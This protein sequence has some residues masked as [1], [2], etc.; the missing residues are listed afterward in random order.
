MNRKMT[1]VVVFLGVLL[2]GPA[3]TTLA[4]VP[5]ANLAFVVQAANNSYVNMNDVVGTHSVNFSNSFGNGTA[6]ATILGGPSPF[7]N[8]TAMLTSSDPGIILGGYVK[9]TIYFEVLG[10]A[11]MS[12][13]MDFL[14]NVTYSPGTLPSPASG[15]RL[16]SY[17]IVSTPA[18]T[19]QLGFIDSTTNPARI[20]LP[21]SGVPG[22][23][24]NQTF[25]LTAGT[26][27]SLTML[28]SVDLNATATAQMTLD[29][30]LFIDPAF[31][32]ANPGFSLLA[33]PGFLVVPE[34]GSIAC[35]CVIGGALF[36][37]NRRHRRPSRTT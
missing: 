14:G 11:G 29:P 24:L 3:V 19:I 28:A 12:V 20:D 1:P 7:L 30:T 23:N 31:L 26:I 15:I 9:L 8:V 33:S 32:A 6:T 17:A 16:E 21:A 37:L 34:P 36:G 22:G 35:L 5:A 4:Q 10:P 18:G 25:N 27:C 2:F 13:P